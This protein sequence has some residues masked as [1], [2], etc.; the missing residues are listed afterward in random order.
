[1]RGI[2]GQIFS[3][4]FIIGTVT[5]IFVLI[6]SIY[7]WTH[8][9]DQIQLSDERKDMLETSN[10]LAI[11]LVETTGD[12]SNWT[13]LGN[14]S[15]N[16]SNILSLGLASSTSKNNKNVSHKG[17]SSGL[18]NSSYLAL[19]GAKI[20]RLVELNLTKYEDMKKIMG[21]LSGSAEF[22]VKIR[23]WENT[24]YIETYK[25]GKEP[26]S[27]SAHVVKTDRYGLLGSDWAHL[28]ISV[29]TPCHNL[30]C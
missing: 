4:D 22:Y 21:I 10:F 14:S 5:F 30:P 20:D 27:F 23:I 15:F 6:G 18:S 12:P 1:M 8:V 16:R 25:F 28:E 3:T 26:P 29:W 13:S 7:V 24:E 9:I 17:V 19:D 2:K 11:T